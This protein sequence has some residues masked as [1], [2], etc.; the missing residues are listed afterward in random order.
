V[1]ESSN[2][3]K[4]RAGLVFLL[5]L[6]AVA[7]CFCYVLIAPF[8]KS[9]LLSA[10]LAILFYPLHSRIDRRIRNR[11]VSALLSTC[12][13]V[14]VIVL[15]AVFLGRALAT[16][17]RDVYQA[18]R[19]SGDGSERLSLYVIHLFERAVELVSSYLPISTSDLRSA[20]VN[21]AEKGVSTLLG[22]TAGVLGSFTALLANALIAFFIL[23][24]LLRD[25][26]AILRRAAVLLPLRR[27]QTRRLFALVKDT[28]NATVYGT[29]TMAALQGALAGLALWFLG[30][31]SA[32]LWAIVTAM[33]A[34]LPWIGTGIVLLPAISMLMFS[35]HWIKGLILL[36]WGLAIVHPVDNLL[37]PHL[38]GSRTK[39]STL[40]VFFALL[41]GLKAFGGLGLF[42][43]P[44][45]L[46][47]TVALLKFLR[48]EK[49]AG[50]WSLERE[51]SQSPP[52]LIGMPKSSKPGETNA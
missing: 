12:L 22:M 9:I 41:G 25:G 33:C 26:N 2:K 45:V 34:L 38:I 46:A 42:I 37:R 10:V 35:G 1:S 5:V 31:T 3:T 21:Q 28:L 4:S 43:G 17:L 13:V 6:T 16:G 49:R 50:S 48:E 7:L 19:S 36:A 11:N 29:L 47:V 52:V 32:G 39:L 15:S 23:F 40:Y 51:T 18:L 8:L 14:L 24:F 20:T 27:D 44:I 30:V